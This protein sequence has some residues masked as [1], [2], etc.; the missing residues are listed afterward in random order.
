MTQITISQQTYNEAKA[1]GYD[2]LFDLVI[3]TIKK[4]FNGQLDA[5]TMQQLNGEQITLWAYYILRDEVMNGGFIQL[6]YNGYGP[7]IFDN[8]F[9]KAMRLWGLR[10][11]SKLI[12]AVKKYYDEKKEELTRERSDEEF[13]AMFEEYPEFDTFDDK[14]VEEEEEYT[15]IIAQYIADNPTLFIHIQD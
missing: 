6:I 1:K 2:A 3:N 11:F 5:Q 4:T 7:F 8:P 14:F 10:D 9:A 12:Y 13:M 15:Q